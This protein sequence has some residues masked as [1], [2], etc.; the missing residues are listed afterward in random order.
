[1]TRS[2]PRIRAAHARFFIAVSPTC[3][4]ALSVVL[5]VL[6]MLGLQP[7]PAEATSLFGWRWAGNTAIWHFEP[8]TGGPPPIDSELGRLRIRESQATWQTANTG[9]SFQLT[10]GDSSSPAVIRSG[11]FRVQYPYDNG[12]PAVVTYEFA[13]DAYGSSVIQRAWMTFNSNKQWVDG[14]QDPSIG[15][16][17]VRAVATHEFGHFAGLADHPMGYTDAVM[18]WDE[19]VK[20]SIIN[21]ENLSGQSAMPAAHRIRC[22]T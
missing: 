19:R 21:F 5:C 14:P 11:S 15:A 8:S 10:E 17:D 2:S 22:R 6:A 18:Y 20:Y 9:S 4:R 13:N 12:T 16:F 7:R 1:M 3:F